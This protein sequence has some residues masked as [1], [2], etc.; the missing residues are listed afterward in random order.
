MA[1]SL[2]GLAI[3]TVAGAQATAESCSGVPLKDKTP[4]LKSSMPQFE[5]LPHLPIRRERPYWDHGPEGSKALS[6]RAQ[7]DG[8]QGDPV[9]RRKHSAMG[10]TGVAAYA[11]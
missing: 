4:T 6:T 10:Q 8:C 9:V 3:P 1:G 7:H 2:I 11:S 5:I